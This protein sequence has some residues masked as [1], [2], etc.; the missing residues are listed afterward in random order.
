M[1][2]PQQFPKAPKICAEPAHLAAKRRGYA[3]IFYASTL[4]AF[5]DI[6]RLH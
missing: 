6:N 4:E 3:L 2:T 5:M 1:K